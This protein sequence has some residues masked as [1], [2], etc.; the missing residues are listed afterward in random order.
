MLKY[1]ISKLQN[2]SLKKSF[3]SVVSQLSGR[4]TIRPRKDC[5]GLCCTL[6]TPLMAT[7]PMYKVYN[8][9]NVYKVYKCILHC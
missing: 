7:T 6:L 4:A 2:C 9:Y 1:Q 5:C 3:S 8:V